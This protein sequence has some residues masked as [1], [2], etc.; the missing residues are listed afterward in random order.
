M[1]TITL[2]DLIGQEIVD[3]RYH[4]ISENEY[5]LQS[6]YAY[7]KLS[8]GVIIDIPHHLDNEYQQKAGEKQNYFE[9]QYRTG[10]LADGDNKSQFE[11]QKIIDFH[12]C[13]Y[14]NEIE[15]DT[16]CYIQL[17]N[18]YYLTENNYGPP[19]I[20]NIDLVILSEEE[21]LAEAKLNDIRSF[22]KTAPQE[23]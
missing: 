23:E 17:S 20:T 19:G 1:E 12:F 8:E 5:G 9:T 6:F 3:L 13:Y 2:F 11:G 16:S 10:Y 22:L 4:Y 21:F 7:I 14:D 18:G 15:D